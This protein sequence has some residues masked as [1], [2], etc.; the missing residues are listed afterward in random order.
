MKRVERIG[1]SPDHVTTLETNWLGAGGISPV[2]LTSKTAARPGYRD[3]ARQGFSQLA[4]RA[5]EGLGRIGRNEQPWSP[6]R[7]CQKGHPVCKAEEAAMF[8]LE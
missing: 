1:L 5:T 6:S 8:H 2:P 3:N 7:I 4:V